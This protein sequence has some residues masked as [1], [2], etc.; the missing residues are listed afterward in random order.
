VFSKGEGGREVAVAF[1]GSP[2]ETT[3]QV[4]VDARRRQQGSEAS[5]SQGR[6]SD[7]SPRKL[8]VSGGQLHTS[9]GLSCASLK[10]GLTTSS[11]DRFGARE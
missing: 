3:S 8:R 9:K 6:E 2:A 4:L 11:G 10:S 7:G 1:N 5:R